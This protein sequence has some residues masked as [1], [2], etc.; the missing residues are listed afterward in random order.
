MRML[1]LDAIALARAQFAFTMTFHIV[2]PALSIGLASYL[3]VLEALWLWT[4][5]DVFIN[6]FKY[7]LK[8]FAI[9]FGMGVVSGIVMSYQFGTNWGRFTARVGNII[10][11]LMGYEVLTAFFLEAGFLGI[12]LFGLE[13]VGPRLHFLATCMVSLGT[14]ISMFWILAAN[15]WR[16][17]PAGYTLVDG[18]FEVVSWP[19]V[20]LN[21]SFP[22]R[23]AHMATAAFLS[24]G[25]AVAG[26]S[27]W[28]LLG[29]R[30]R[31]FAER[32]FSLATWMVA[33]AGPL[34]VVIGDLHGLNTIEH[35]PTKVAAMEGHWETSRDVPLLLF[36]WPDQAA[37]ANRYEVGIPRLGSL[38]LTHSWGG[39]IEG[40]EEVPPEDRPPVAIVFFAFW[41]M[42]GLGFL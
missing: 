17:T 23:L 31:A 14:L 34:Q 9:A 37:A 2:F 42:V 26:I 28:Y 7:W 12:M 13:R 41:V 8:I 6:L 29:N 16:Q 24:T 15:S 11:P 3:A 25:V 19:A 4:G 10:G 27:A 39:E 5:R 21:P 18:K 36:A 32:G 22:Y 1:G 30:H 20:I 40:L 35:Q 38:I 33:I